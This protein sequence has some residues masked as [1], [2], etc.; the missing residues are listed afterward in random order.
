M[1]ITEFSWAHSDAKLDQFFIC[2]KQHNQQ[3]LNG[4]STYTNCTKIL[5]LGSPDELRRGL[6]E[7]DHQMVEK[8]IKNFKIKG[9]HRN[10]ARTS[11][12]IERLTQTSASQTMF[13]KDGDTIDVRA[14]FQKALNLSLPSATSTIYEETEWKT[15]GRDDGVTCQNP[16]FRTNKVNA[17]VLPAPYHPLSR[18]QSCVTYMIRNWLFFKP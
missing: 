15:G 5:G 6:S 11:Y 17:R 1:E 7:R 10:E 4:R 12:N 8:T 9:N 16:S 3:L 13:K 2:K 18:V 14:Y